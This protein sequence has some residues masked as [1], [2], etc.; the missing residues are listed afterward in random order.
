MPTLPSSKAGLAP[1]SHNQ[2]LRYMNLY[3][4][5]FP[6]TYMYSRLVIDSVRIVSLP[7]GPERYRTLVI[8]NSHQPASLLMRAHGLSA[9]TPSS[10]LLTAGCSLA[11][12]MYMSSLWLS[13]LAFIS[14]PWNPQTSSL[15]AGRPTSSDIDYPVQWRDA[16]E[17]L[18]IYKF[19][20]QS[21][22]FIPFYVHSSE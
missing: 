16:T 2:S 21:K 19:E 11:C 7:T 10:C 15:H 20:R 4:K 17:Q 3:K 18:D 6:F 8:S 9:L 13:P 22:R 14:R 12:V 5:L 1:P